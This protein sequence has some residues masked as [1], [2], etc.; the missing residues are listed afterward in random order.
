MIQSGGRLAAYSGCTGVGRCGPG[1]R[2][3]L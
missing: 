1:A 2:A 3:F